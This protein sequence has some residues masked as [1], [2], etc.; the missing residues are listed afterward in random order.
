MVRLT[1]SKCEKQL[2]YSCTNTLKCLGERQAF[3]RWMEDSFNS[4]FNRALYEVFTFAAILAIYTKTKKKGCH[5]PILI[6]TVFRM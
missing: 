5:K 3:S 4:K 2:K 6:L 1:I